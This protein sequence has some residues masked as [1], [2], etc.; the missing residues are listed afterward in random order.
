MS[1]SDW[2]ANGWIVPHPT[3]RHEVAS[4]LGV[5]ERN[6]ADAAVEGLSSDS[7][8]GFAYP[9][10]SSLDSHSRPRATGPSGSERRAVTAMA[11]I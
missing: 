1:L 5:V 8:L 7:R 3:S 11:I 6:L 10:Y 2:E 4:L 9:P